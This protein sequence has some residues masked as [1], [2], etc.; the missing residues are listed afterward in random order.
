MELRLTGA[1]GVRDGSLLAVKVGAKRCY[2]PFHA[3]LLQGDGGACKLPSLP[4][5]ATCEHM[6]VE[7]FEP[8]AHARLLLKP[9]EKRWSIDLQQRPEAFLRKNEASDQPAVQ[10][11]ERNPASVPSVE[12]EAKAAGSTGAAVPPLRLSSSCGGSGDAEEVPGSNHSSTRTEPR[13]RQMACAKAQPYMERHC[14]LK[15]MQTLLQSVIKEQ[16]NDPYGYMIGVLQSSCQAQQGLFS[17]AVDPAKRSGGKPDAGGK[18]ARPHSATAKLSG[19]PRLASLE[20][21]C[22]ANSLEDDAPTLVQQCENVPQ[23]QQPMEAKLV[24][25]PQPQKQLQQPQKPAFHV[26]NVQEPPQLDSQPAGV[27]AQEQ[28]TQSF[29]TRLQQGH[30]KFDALDEFPDPPVAPPETPQ[31]LQHTKELANDSACLSSD[32]SE[33]PLAP[34][35]EPSDLSEPPLAPPEERT[36]P[37]P[38]AADPVPPAPAKRKPVELGPLDTVPATSI[39]LE[40]AEPTAPEEQEMEE[41]RRRWWSQ[42][43]AADGSMPSAGGS[44]VF[45]LRKQGGATLHEPGSLPAGSGAG[46]PSRPRPQSATASRAPVREQRHRPQSATS[47]PHGQ[48]RARPGLQL[49]S[50]R[51]MSMVPCRLSPKVP[52]RPLEPAQHPATAPLAQQAAPRLDLHDSCALNRLEAR[53]DADAMATPAAAAGAARNAASSRARCGFPVPQRTQSVPSLSLTMPVLAPQSPAAVQKPQKSMTFPRSEQ[54]ETKAGAKTAVA[55]A[56]EPSTGPT[57]VEAMDAQHP[58]CQLQKSTPCEADGDVLPQQQQ[59]QQQ[60]PASDKVVGEQ[61]AADSN[62]FAPSERVPLSLRFAGCIS[63]RSEISDVATSIGAVSHAACLVS[64]ECRNTWAEQW[65]A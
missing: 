43:A 36:A 57:P 53:A 28:R 22:H 34:P 56:W 32:L 45:L 38:V 41:R 2:L 18:R 63:A 59:Q 58:Q 24:E 13:Q 20:E 29:P 1:H 27:T 49:S 6:K 39:S 48:M 37:V 8:V 7:L 9:T 33:P 23:P 62:V 4:V 3:E 5:G 30:Q 11:P 12:F 25:Q 64:S 26:P 16:P 55:F 65:G 10:W 54:P 51:S 46:C 15:V 52:S 44:P 40:A 14:L 31:V 35:E 42:E 17:A 61:P 50:V 21:G 19:E 60:L 47:Y